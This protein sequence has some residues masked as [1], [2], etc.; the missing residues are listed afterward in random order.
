MAGASSSG[1]SASWHAPPASAAVVHSVCRTVGRQSC[2]VGLVVGGAR[3]GRASV[4]SC[5]V[6]R[7]PGPARGA[8]RGRQQEPALAHG[9]R[10]TFLAGCES[11]R[12][13]IGSCAAWACEHRVRRSLRGERGER[14]GCASVGGGRQQHPLCRHQRVC[15]GPFCTMAAVCVAELRDVDAELADEFLVPFNVCGVRRRVV[16]TLRD[17]LPLVDDGGRRLGDVEDPIRSQCAKGARSARQ[18]PRRS[19]L[20]SAGVAVD[21]HDNVVPSRRH[22]A[23]VEPTSSWLPARVEDVVDE[24]SRRAADEG[25]VLEDEPEAQLRAFEVHILLRYPALSS[26]GAIAARTAAAVTGELVDNLTMVL[27]SSNGSAPGDRA[28]LADEGTDDDASD[29]LVD[30]RCSNADTRSASDARSFAVLS[31]FS[32]T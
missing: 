16:V 24:V 17:R 25:A 10:A 5:L 12:A 7:R 8:V 28:E 11:A 26:I 2:G 21:I 14:G 18:V 20:R 32:S 22:D 4:W 19:T 3:C 13:S 29:D 1:S 6:E 31:V 27:S 9:R 30:G 23:N 15:A